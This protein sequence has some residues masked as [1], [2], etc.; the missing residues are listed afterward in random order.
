[1]EPEPDTNHSI[2]LGKGIMYLTFKPSS[3]RY[4]YLMATCQFN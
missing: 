4:L 1:M 3:Q 2:S